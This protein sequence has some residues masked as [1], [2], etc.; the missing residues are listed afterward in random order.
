MG[1]ENEYKAVAVR[2]GLRVNRGIYLRKA[3]GFS[4]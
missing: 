2:Y 4:V 1:W 3:L